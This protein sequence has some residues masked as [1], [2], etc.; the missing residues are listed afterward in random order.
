MECTTEVVFNVGSLYS[1]FEKI[2]DKRKPRGKRYQLVHILVMMVLAKLCG[3]DTPSGIAD[4][5][6]DR[7]EQMIAMLNLKRKTMPHHSTY[8]RVTE[9]VIDVEELEQT[10]SVVLSAP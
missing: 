8:R 7:S 6:Q 1:R 9:E 4:W 5:V 2:K 3:E 10:V